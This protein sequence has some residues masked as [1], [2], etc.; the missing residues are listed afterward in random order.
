MRTH[1]HTLCTRVVWRLPGV[2]C[3][4]HSIYF[5]FVFGVDYLTHPSIIVDSSSIAM[6]LIFHLAF[7]RSPLSLPP[8]FIDSSYMERFVAYTNGAHIFWLSAA[9]DEC[10]SDKRF[11][12]PPQEIHSAQIERINQSN[13]EIECECRHNHARP[14]EWLCEHQARTF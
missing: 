1:L 8:C 7:L 9:I 12:L 4:V 5:R 14:I 3:C 6:S 10:V 2:L 11:T 13:C